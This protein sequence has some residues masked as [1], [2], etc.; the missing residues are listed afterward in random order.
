M[1]EMRIVRGP[2]VGLT[3]WG[4]GD[5]AAVGGDLRQLEEGYAVLDVVGK[6]ADVRTADA[7]QRVEY[8]SQNGHRVTPDAA[9]DNG[10]AIVERPITNPTSTVQLLILTHTQAIPD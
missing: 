3:V 9:A 2:K 1:L 6:L 8:G 4:R 5:A 10:L 7:R